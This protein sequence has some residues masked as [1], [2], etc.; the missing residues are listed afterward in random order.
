MEKREIL[1]SSVGFLYKTML[2]RDP[3]KRRVKPVKPHLLQ[4]DFAGLDGSSDDS[5]FK[6]TNDDDDDDD[7]DD[8]DDDYS[9]DDSDDG[10]DSN[11]DKKY[12][13]DDDNEEACDSI[14][15]SNG[16]DVNI[17]GK[18][19][20]RPSLIEKKELS[21]DGK[22]GSSPGKMLKLLVCCICLG[23]YS[24]QDNEIV[25][26]D[27][28]GASVHEGCYGI[29]EVESFDSSASS[30]STEPWFCDAC[31]AG[32][33]PHCELCPNSGGIYKET[34]ASRWV[35]LVCALYIP[36]VA[37]GD[38]DKLSNIT[39][40]EMS[41]AKW[42]A[43]ECSLCQDDRF[44][45]TGICIT[46]DAG[47]C[48]TYFHV[49]CAQREGLLTEASPDEEIADPFFA[50]CKQHADKQLVN[51]KRRNWLV[52]QSCMKNFE[53]HLCDKDKLR[54]QRKL[55]THQQL[56]VAAKEQQAAAW[57]PTVKMPRMLITSAHALGQLLKKAELF[58]ITQMESVT[59][60]RKKWHI[61][62][63][64]SVDYVGYYLDRNMRIDNMKCH[65]QELL[66]QRNKLEAQETLLHNRYEQLSRDVACLRS[67]SKDLQEKGETLWNAVNRLAARRLRWKGTVHF[68]N[69]SKSSPQKISAL[70][71]TT[72]LNRCDTCKKTHNQHLLVKCD[73]CH[74][75]H[76]LGCL[77]PPL[78]RMPKKTKLQGWQ[79]S[80]CACQSSSGDDHDVLSTE[81]RQLRKK[82]LIHEPVKYTSMFV[83]PLAFRKR[84]QGRRIRA[85]KNKSTISNSQKNRIDMS[86]TV[87]SN[88]D[89]NMIDDVHQRH[90]D[91]SSSIDDVKLK[92]ISGLQH[93]TDVADLSP[94]DEL[95]M[96]APSTSPTVHAEKPPVINSETATGTL[97]ASHHRLPR[98][99]SRNVLSS[100]YRHKPMKRCVPKRRLGPNLKKSTLSTVKS[101]VTKACSERIVEK[102]NSCEEINTLDVH[103]ATSSKIQIATSREFFY[104]SRND[105]MRRSLSL[106]VSSAVIEISDDESI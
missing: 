86:E 47:M 85:R 100:C 14:T 3:C 71:P 81:P 16:V 102:L 88:H 53:S 35:H 26:C 36:G 37:F 20:S 30:A 13:D 24:E 44:S 78:T 73:K 98:K 75:H 79:C 60:I 67:N 76:H 87:D 34:D 46:C 32:V 23:D 31:K 80:R 29:T 63:T 54:V 45:R 18:L 62:P 27:S 51:V 64:L 17:D 52:V 12:D 70:S 72:L 93:N 92:S 90:N 19:P 69:L 59:D 39:L 94:K 41:Y 84:R 101:Q 48:R 33:K 91:M 43:K 50:Y 1:E 5:D 68:Q 104:S 77:D 105:P 8:G 22:I 49:T 42:G 103:C 97:Q 66:S 6:V 82:Y 96:V 74:K 83:N 9:D 40:F 25:E 2:E 55:T 11:C 10:R 61:S 21:A 4:L 58:G 7:D 89:V 65:V 106:P 99:R 28:C 15:H 95:R 38:V 56:F 57:V